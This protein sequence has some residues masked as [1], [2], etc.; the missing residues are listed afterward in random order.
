MKLGIPSGPAV[1][2]ALFASAALAAASPALATVTYHYGGSVPPVN[3]RDGGIVSYID[4]N[5]PIEFDFTLATDIAANLTNV[6][7]KASMLSWTVTGGK[8]ASTVD[9]TDV[10]ALLNYAR[11]TTD[12][13]HNITHWVIA[14]H[15]D[16]AVLPQDQLRFFFDSGAGNSET[17]N[18]IRISNGL[19]TGGATSTTGAVGSFAKLPGRAGGVPEPES[20]AL[21]IAG[22]AGAGAMLRRRRSLLAV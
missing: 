19:N 21:M 18:W 4:A 6:D 14:G 3:S 22:F 1:A 15:A 9:S 16:I 11:F 7:I 2:F 10:A 12:S 20:W 13:L 8:A 5:A 17:L